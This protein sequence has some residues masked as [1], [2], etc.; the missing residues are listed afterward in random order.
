MAHAHVDFKVFQRK[1]INF[2]ILAVWF[3]VGSL[4]KI[5]WCD[6]ESN[7]MLIL[8]FQLQGKKKKK[9]FT[10]SV[11]CEAANWSPKYPNLISARGLCP[12]GP[13]AG[14]FPCTPLG[15]R[16]PLDPGHLGWVPPK[17]FFQFPCLPSDRPPLFWRSVLLK[18][19]HTFFNVNE[20][21]R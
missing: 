1:L 4:K 9:V 3:Y 14:C 12:P 8:M 19:F 20:P 11:H 6:R 7:E 10:I 21:D 15:P 5:G 13:P 16:R 2:V 18:P 17:H